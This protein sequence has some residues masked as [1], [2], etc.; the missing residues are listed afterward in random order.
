M[1]RHNVASTSVQR[2]LDVMCLNITINL[3]LN[4][5]SGGKK[6]SLWKITAKTKPIAVGQRA[7]NTAVKR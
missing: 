6:S 7:Y 1:R 5:E 3:L 4:K 2:Q